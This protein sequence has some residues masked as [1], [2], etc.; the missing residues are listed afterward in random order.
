MARR[1][2]LYAAA[3]ALRR[4]SYEGVSAVERE[5]AGA[6]EKA[7]RGLLD[8]GGRLTSEQ[9]SRRV[10]GALTCCPLECQ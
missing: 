5:G 3:E 2:D 6:E 4:P 9:V 1:Y 10:Q 8:S 7:L